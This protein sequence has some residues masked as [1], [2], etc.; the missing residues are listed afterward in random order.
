MAEMVGRRNGGLV[1]TADPSSVDDILDSY[2]MPGPERKH[3][4]PTRRL[5]N[6]KDSTWAHK[7]KIRDSG[8]QK[9]EYSQ[10]YCISPGKSYVIE[11]QGGELPYDMAE[12]NPQKFYSR[13]LNQDIKKCKVKMRGRLFFMWTQRPLLRI[14]MSIKQKLFNR[15]QEEIGEEFG[16]EIADALDNEEIDENIKELVENDQIELIGHDNKPLLKRQLTL[17]QEQQAQ[18]GGTGGDEDILTEGDSL[19]IRTSS[20]DSKRLENAELQI[21]EQNYSDL[22]D[23]V[24]G[25]VKQHSLKKEA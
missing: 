20:P 12:S 4:S 19:N 17:L 10:T 16:Q 25:F 2:Y 11:A 15:L 22:K 21:H 1:I 13:V 14:I 7:Q 23:Q 3:K 18:L 9:G 6:H 5:I 24:T 8:L